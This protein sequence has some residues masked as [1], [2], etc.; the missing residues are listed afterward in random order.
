VKRGK[1]VMYL[2][3]LGPKEQAVAEELREVGKKELA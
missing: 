3:K 2:L 1:N